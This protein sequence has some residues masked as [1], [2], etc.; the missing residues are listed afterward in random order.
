[1]RRGDVWLA[2]IGQKLRPVVVLT[3][4]QV[5]GVR[6][7]VVVAEVTTQARGSHVEVSVD[8]ESVGL[9]RPSVVNA[10]GIHTIAQTRLT[11]HVGTLAP[12]DMSCVC[13]AVRRAIGC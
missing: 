2:Q 6:R 12:S 13:T 5:I 7:L 3:R 1:M 9:D 10:D 11:H 4:D 8:H